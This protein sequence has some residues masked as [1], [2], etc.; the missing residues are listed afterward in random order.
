MTE[1]FRTLLVSRGMPEDLSDEQ[2][3]EWADKNLARADEKPAEEVERSENNADDEKPET[4]P[5]DHRA[6]ARQA[7]EAERTRAFDIIDA[8]EVAGLERSVADDM[9][10]RGIS[11]EV[12]R[13]EIFKKMAERGK[14]PVGG[15]GDPKL[16]SEGID[17]FRD[18][19]RDALIIRCCKS[20]Q[21]KR[22]P[23]SAD[24]PAATGHEDFLHGS[25][26]RLAAQCLEYLPGLNVNRL[27][28]REIFQLAM[29]NRDALQR[30][31]VLARSSD[32]LA[33]HVTGMFPNLLLDAYNKSLLGA[34]DEAPVTFPIW[35]RQAPSVPDFKNIHRIRF[36]ELSNPE[37]V[38][39]NEKY[40]DAKFSDAKETYK[41]EKYGQMTSF[42]WE[43]FV[44]DDLDA[45]SRVPA[46]HGNAMRRRQ[47]RAVYSIL[48]DNPAMG[49]TGLLF[50]A[51][52]QTTAGGHA[53]LVTSGAAP[54]ATTLNAGYL[55]MATKTGLNSNVTLNITPQF[56]LA[57]QALAA[58]VLQLLASNTPPDVGGNATGT[59][60]VA[61]LYG[62][63]GPRRLTPVFDA[64]MD[65]RST[66]A[67]FLAASTD[68]V[69]TIEI[70][71]LEGEESPVVDTEQGF[72]NDTLKF[73][74]RQTFG[75]KAID[76]RGLYENDGS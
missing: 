14:P 29:G 54:S 37:L 25:V 6:L 17:R 2:A 26:K 7:A 27:S 43:T 58:T 38:P 45:L 74:I 40:P 21:L 35:T 23:F 68:Q 19:A 42:S 62:P 61:N 15:A 5:V 22:E 51:T 64:E 36:G 4:P 56:I 57:P 18:A 72:D 3:V 44:N 24:K 39:E 76:F 30:S 69:D 46:M 65:L 60:G 31:G 55:S 49:D 20:A 33:Y 48:Y 71:F 67:W 11:V 75:T 28:Q 13:T 10:R 34:Y 50:N 32:G 59:S 12:A 52:A 1:Q 63:G 53:N 73:K 70:A 47:N 8:V 16:T 66:V 41:V 9:V